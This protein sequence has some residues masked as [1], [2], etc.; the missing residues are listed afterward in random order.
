MPK[1]N[2]AHYLYLKKK[3]KSSNMNMKAIF[4]CFLNIL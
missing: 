3:K 2:G 1:I 4:G